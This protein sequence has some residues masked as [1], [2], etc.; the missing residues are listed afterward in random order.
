MCPWEAGSATCHDRAMEEMPPLVVQGHPLLKLRLARDACSFL[1]PNR[2]W[3][4]CGELGFHVAV[5]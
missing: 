3:G 1:V 4:R 5:H 2:V